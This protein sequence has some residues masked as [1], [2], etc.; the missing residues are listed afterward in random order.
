MWVSGNKKP[1][2]IPGCAPLRP[3]RSKTV[4]FYRN[5]YKAAQRYI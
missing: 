2:R 3:I 5:K 4:T 1:N